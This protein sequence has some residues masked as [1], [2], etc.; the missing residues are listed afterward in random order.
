MIESVIKRKKGWM[1]AWLKGRKEDGKDER[2]HGLTS[3]ARLNEQKDNKR[4]S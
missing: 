4:L 2:M 3:K 1:K